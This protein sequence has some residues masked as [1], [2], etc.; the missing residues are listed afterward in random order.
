MNDMLKHILLALTLLTV[1][2]ALKAETQEEITTKD[3]LKYT[4]I[5]SDDNKY[6]GAAIGGKVIVPVRYTKL[7]A[8][9]SGFAAS[10]REKSGHSIV[11]KTDYYTPEGLCITEDW[12]NIEQVRPLLDYSQ[13]QKPSGYFKFTIKGKTGILDSKG[14]CISAPQWEEVSYT[15]GVFVV[16]DFSGLKGIINPLTSEVII[17]PAYDQISLHGGFFKVKLNGYEGAIVFADKNLSELTAKDFRLVIKPNRYASVTRSKG[18]YT[19]YSGTGSNGFCTILDADGKV[20]VKGGRYTKIYHLANGYYEA[21]IGNRS[22]ILNEKGEQLFFTEYNGL[23]YDDKQNCYISY[24]GNAKGKVALDGTVI[25][26]PK[27][28]VTRR[29]TKD[30]PPLVYVTDTK[31]NE[32]METPDGKVLV[33]CSYDLVVNYSSGYLGLHRDGF[34][35]AADLSG[36]ILIPIER[37]YHFTVRR[38]YK[39]TPYFS[40]YKGALSGLCDSVG[41][42][43]IAPDRWNYV[44][45]FDVSSDGKFSR[46]EVRSDKGRG[47]IDSKGNIIVPPVYTRLFKSSV[48]PGM[49]SVYNGEFQGLV[50][51]D[52]DEIIPPKYNKVNTISQNIDKQN[53][54]YKVSNGDFCGVYNSAGDC[55]LPADRFTYVSIQPNFETDIAEK[56]VIKATVGD[57]VAFHSLNG[58]LLKKTESPAKRREYLDKAHDAF[59]SE[60]WSD[61]SKYYIKAHEI[62]AD[63]SSAFNVGASYYNSGDYGKA[64]KWFRKSIA[65]PHSDENHN[66]LCGLIDDCESIQAQRKE[67]RASL[68]AGLF[69]TAVN[70]GLNIYQMNQQQKARRKNMKSGNWKNYQT[71]GYSS[72][73]SSEDSESDGAETN[74]PSKPKSASSCGACGGK[75]YTIEYVANYGIDKRPYCEECGKTVTSG[76]YHRTCTRC[77][78][79]GKL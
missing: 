4:L 38:N 3:G 34:E 55:L 78:G 18:L 39:K 15:F 12:P 30:T 47:I 64:L 44:S 28:T 71:G 67:Q 51:S 65:F 2:L 59:S 61:A 19:A 40:V 43:V 77:G 36:N 62:S 17:K 5:R 22:G 31:G 20:L 50:N 29:I 53:S 25:E 56:N 1:T 70:T 35:G 69:V 63:Y 33:P 74:L 42:E 26:E 45:P 10:L 46:F 49:I 75:G 6:M 57:V 37:K 52:G 13:K 11:T 32:G 68:I 66:T 79:T 14:I 54:Y 8:S 7:D 58:K 60:K 76:H 72:S 73:S 48:I 41:R 23:G 24:L 21:R 16:K 27:P 9:L